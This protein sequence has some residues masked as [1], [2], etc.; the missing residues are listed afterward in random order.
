MRT[1]STLSPTRSF[2]A[3]SLIL[4]FLFPVIAPAAKADLQWK[5]HSS[6]GVR[7]LRQQKFELA[8]QEFLRATWIQKD[9]SEGFLY[10]GWAGGGLL[11]PGN[12]LR[13]IRRK[14]KAER[15]MATFQ[16]FQATEMT[17]RQEML[18]SMREVV[19]PEAS[20]KSPED[21]T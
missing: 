17:E 15:A 1:Q 18:K 19:Q 21:D 8:R 12:R 6:R 9:R 2:L 7:L 16:Q 13:P 3:V 10:V 5:T 20:L 14:E 4:L 11:S